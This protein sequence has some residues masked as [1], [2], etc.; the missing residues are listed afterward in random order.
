MI[1]RLADYC[2]G[3]LPGFGV[4]P[5]SRTGFIP[6][7]HVERLH[8]D[9][10]FEKTL[11]FTEKY[12]EATQARALLTVITPLAPMLTLELEA[13]GFSEASY[14]ER[15]AVLARN[16]DI[17]L[18]GHYMRQPVLPCR[19]VHNYWNETSLIASQVE[20]ERDWLERSGLMSRRV[21]SAGW[22]H[23]DQ[24]LVKT[25]GRLGFEM[26]FSASSARFNDSPAAFDIRALRD[27]PVIFS[28]A[29][30]E[31]VGGI[32]AVSSLGDSGSR[33]FVARR[34]FTAFPA[35]VFSKSESF[36]SLYSHDW[37]LNVD[38]AM[39][40]VEELKAHGASFVSLDKLLE[41][42]SIVSHRRR[43]VSA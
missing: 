14:R 15:I 20:R 33:S 37:D 24:N 8:H 36:L 23:M 16:A 22:W 35:L 42:R 5:L 26:D 41:R 1:S 29:T 39:K 40:T 12:Q 21:Y 7:L 25:L 28:H 10:S 3:R 18:H 38:G 11:E 17:G 13:A 31:T 2:I 27:A 9:E 30:D 32:W 43:A 19:P 6:V 4:R 34:V